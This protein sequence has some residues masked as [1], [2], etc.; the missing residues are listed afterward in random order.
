MSR[1][2]E[3]L[4]GTLYDLLQDSFTLPLGSDRCVVDK[5]K[6]LGLI[7]EITAALPGYLKDAKRIAEEEN[8][9]IA[10]AKR[11]AE[12]SRRH[13]EEQAKRLVSEQEILTVARQKAADL[14]QNAE[15]KSKEILKATNE[16]VDDLLKRTED[17]INVA[18][19]QVKQARSEFRAAARRS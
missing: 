8:V 19:T 10:K 14:T 16:Y 11:D 9:I 2:V 18:L 1:D 13:A 3:E 4:L 15:K 5:D 7:D 17:A 6:A 12:A